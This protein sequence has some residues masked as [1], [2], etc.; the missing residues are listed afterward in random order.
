MKAAITKQA[1][2]GFETIL[3][4]GILKSLIHARQKKVIK[5]KVSVNIVATAAPK[6]LYSGIKKKFKTIFINAPAPAISAN[7]FWLFAEIKTNQIQ[8]YKN[9]NNTSQ[10]KTWRARTELIKFL[11]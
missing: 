2:T 10:D 6:K 11:P 8:I 1:K 9:F 4:I 3:K 7:L 5:I